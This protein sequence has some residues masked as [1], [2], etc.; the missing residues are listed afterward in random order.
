MNVLLINPRTDDMIRTEIPGYVS[1]EVGRFPPLGLLYVTGYLLQRTA[2]QVA[3]IDMPADDLSYEALARR[4][5]RDRP[6]VVG[7]TGTT[8][9]LVEIERCVRCARQA[10]PDAV[11]CLGGPHVDAYPRESAEMDGVDFALRGE[12]EVAFAE[13]LDALQAKRSVADVPGLC[14]RVDGE[15]IVC[16]PGAPPGALDE[17]P[18]P[19]RHLLPAENYFYV[20]GKRATFTTLLSSRGCPYRCI[21]CSTPRGPYRMR[22][23][24]NIVDEMQRCLEAGAEEI[25]FI[26]DTFNARRGRLGVISQE[27]L[28]RGVQ[29][30]WSFR[31][32]ADTLDRDELAL[33]ARAGCERMHLGVET[34][35]DPGLEQLRKGITTEEV[36]RGL[37]WARECG[38]TTAAYFMIGCPHEKTQADVRR[39]IDFACEAGPDFALFNIL[40]IYPHTELHAMAVEKGLIDPDEWPNFVRHPRPDFEMRFWEESF[41]RAQLMDLLRT[42]YRRFY[43]RPSLIWRN[44]RSLGSLSE[45]RHKAAAGLSIL[46]GG[47]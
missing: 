18:L 40:T 22:S 17:L 25:H 13:L 34:G 28:D 37:A 1:R 5:T 29:V 39:S 35:D 12:A 46:T 36:R 45:L 16:E 44:L 23:A 30:K 6:D 26:D 8:H 15:T 11:I 21:F 20:L 41:D 27:I 14:Y 10:L 2:H 32:R 43:L 42:A 33:A 47:R 7:V 38:I 31:G 3:V 24:P 9:N 19:A 4:L